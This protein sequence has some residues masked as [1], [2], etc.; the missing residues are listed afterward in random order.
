MIISLDFLRSQ[1]FFIPPFPC[2]L[3]LSKKSDT[4][5]LNAENLLQNLNE[6]AII[7]LSDTDC[8]G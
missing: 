5:K 4:Y 2:N 3:L 7:S 6:S 8:I 1:A